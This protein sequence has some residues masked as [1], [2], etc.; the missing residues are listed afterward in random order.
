MHV[1]LYKTD[2]FTSKTGH[3]SVKKTAHEDINFLIFDIFQVQNL[4]S[5]FLKIME[6]TVAHIQNRDPSFI[7]QTCPKCQMEEE[8]VLPY[9]Q[10]FVHRIILMC[11]P[12]R[13]V[14]SP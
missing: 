8:H 9:T 13:L 2:L 12:Q 5:H 7:S 4:Y 11:H 1:I 6:N 14:Y 3:F 10:T